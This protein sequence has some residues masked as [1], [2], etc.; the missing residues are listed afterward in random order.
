MDTR[1]TSTYKL[2]MDTGQESTADPCSCFLALSS[3]P[4]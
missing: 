4:T 2:M 3:D 1:S